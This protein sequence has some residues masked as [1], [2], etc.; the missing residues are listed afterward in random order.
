MKKFYML[1]TGL[2]M[3]CGA[4]AQ[5]I[6][7]NSGTSNCLKSIYFTDANTGYAV[8]NAGTILKTSDGGLNWTTQSSG[9]NAYL[10]EIYFP[11]SSKGFAVGYGIYAGHGILLATSNGGETWEKLQDEIIDNGEWFSIDFINSFEGYIAG[12]YN[13]KGCILKTYDTGNTWSTFFINVEDSN[14][15]DVDGSSLNS[16]DFIDSNTGFAS[17]NYLCGSQTGGSNV[18]FLLKSSNAGIDW[19]RVNNSFYWNNYY[20]SLFFTDSLT[21]YMIAGKKWGWAQGYD[22]LFKTTDGGF[23]WSITNIGSGAYGLSSIYFTDP[24]TGFL[25]G[26]FGK[27]F[28]TEDGGEYYYMQ[29]SGTTSILTS[30]YF[31]DGNIGYIAGDSGVILKTTNGGGSSTGIENPEDQS[32]KFK[33]QSYPNP[34]GGIVDLQFTIYN[35]E[36]ITLK[37]YNA[38]GQKVA[39]VLD[40]S[41]PAGE[42]T[43]RWDAGGL[44]AGI[45]FYRLTIDDP[46]GFA[47]RTGQRLTTSSGKILKY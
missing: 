28:K 44:P 25:V 32:A 29:N 35:R 22:S 5:W 11:T 39:V 45:Y 16:I 23:N 34:T 27:I 26:H 43:V 9:T 6:P 18:S 30:V 19:V 14:C 10:S 17:G 47:L 7:Q 4:R 41:L 2:I 20:K 8:G 42:H 1:I 15:Y 38:Q 33:V 13:G 36:S 3:L 12:T 24:D 37:I 46:S 31:V 21:G 40:E